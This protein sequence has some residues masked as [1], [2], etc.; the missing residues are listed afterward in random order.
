[1]KRKGRGQAEV[2]PKS[3][4]EKKR[5]L[6]D[7]QE[8]SRHEDA[9]FKGPT[10]IS[11]I[12]TP[13]MGRGTRTRPA[14]KKRTA[15][16]PNEQKAR[17][18]GETPVEDSTGQAGGNA[19]VRQRRKSSLLEEQI[20]DL[21]SDVLPSETNTLSG[22]GNE[23]VRPMPPSFR[24]SLRSFRE[25]GMMSEAAEQYHLN[26]GRGDSV[27]VPGEG[28]RKSLLEDVLRKDAQKAGE[29][30]GDGG[31]SGWK[32]GR[33]LGQGSFGQVILWEKARRNGPV[34][35]QYS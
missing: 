19:D 2:R 18:Q 30:K 22:A 21:L 28:G 10:S 35:L 15:V 29:N 13:A 14:A 1:M 8:P 3:P 23:N 12:D 25:Q 26:L 27:R 33:V 32:P 5:K 4:P 6:E 17:G 9:D 16:Q 24:N 34:W 20:L 31:E 11:G 7:Q